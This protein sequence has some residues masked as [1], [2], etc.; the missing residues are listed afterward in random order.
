MKK[1]IEILNY[2][3]HTVNIIQQGKVKNLVSVGNARCIQETKKI[4]EINNI[5]I[6]STTFGQVEGLPEE[7]EGV[8]YIVSRLILQ[9]CPQ[10]RD[11]LVPND[12]VRDEEGKIIG[13]KS[14]ANN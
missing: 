7:K 12:I 8:Y 1:N 14:L 13:C 10:R 2:T 4:G 6:T 5:P 9:A 3:P 11:L